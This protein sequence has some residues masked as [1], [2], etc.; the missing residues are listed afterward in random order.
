MFNNGILNGVDLMI[1]CAK[2]RHSLYY[3]I[4]IIYINLSLLCMNTAVKNFFLSEIEN[5]N[6]T[7]REISFLFRG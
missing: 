2:I 3:V 4:D 6:Y 5:C 7:I 1:S